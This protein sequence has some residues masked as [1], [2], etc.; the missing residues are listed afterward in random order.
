MNELSD[1]QVCPYC[2]SEVED[3][4]REWEE[5]EHVIECDNCRK[6]YHVEVHYKFLGWE[7]QKYC[8]ECNEKEEECF[9]GVSVD[10]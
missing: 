3:H 10:E 5:G 2:N 1:T 9:C 7:V 8:T 6:H 4:Q